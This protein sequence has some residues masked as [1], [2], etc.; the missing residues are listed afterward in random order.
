MILEVDGTQNSW[1]VLC[2]SAKMPCALPGTTA[3]IIRHPWVL[4]IDLGVT[5]MR[6]DP[7]LLVLKQSNTLSLGW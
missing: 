2:Q 3:W 1:D 7:E 4:R 5:H 6:E